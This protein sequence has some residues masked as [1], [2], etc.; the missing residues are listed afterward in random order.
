[1]RASLSTALANATYSSETT[2]LWAFG[3]GSNVDSETIKSIDPKWDKRMDVDDDTNHTLVADYIVLNADMCERTTATTSAT[4]TTGT[5]SIS[6]DAYFNISNINDDYYNRNLNSNIYNNIICHNI[7]NLNT[8]SR[9]ACRPG[10][11]AGHI[12]IHYC[13][14]QL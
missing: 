2:T 5:T 12:S 14:M 1:M 7:G 3:I 9:A 11:C 4:T 8:V 13:R 6:T 10:L